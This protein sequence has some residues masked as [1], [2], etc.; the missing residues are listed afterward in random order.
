M[1][2]DGYRDVLGISCYC[3]CH[4]RLWGAQL[5]ENSPTTSTTEPVLP[6]LFFQGSLW[7]FER[8]LY[9]GALEFILD[10]RR[11][12]IPPAGCSHV[13][14]KRAGVH[15]VC[16][17]LLIATLVYCNIIRA[18]VWIGSTAGCCSATRYPPPCTRDGCSYLE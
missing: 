5:S 12:T 7:G 13:E 15:G 17:A 6:S 14:E 11:V 1:M 18:L 2:C 9:P 3:K 4:G 10:L 8:C 16:V